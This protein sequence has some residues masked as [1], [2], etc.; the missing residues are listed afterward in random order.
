VGTL[1]CKDIKTGNIIDVAPGKL[2]REQRIQ[3]WNEKDAIIGKMIKY[4][5][6]PKGVKDKPRFPTF[7]T[8][9]MGSDYGD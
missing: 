5:T 2:T 8:F 4:K 7:Q 3:F 9:R 1:I 6:F